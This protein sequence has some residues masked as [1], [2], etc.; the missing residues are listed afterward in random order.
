[1][2]PGEVFTLAPRQLGYVDLIKQVVAERGLP[3]TAARYAIAAAGAESSLTNWE[4]WGTSILVG[5]AEGRPLNA[6]ELAVA[7]RSK[8]LG[9]GPYRVNGLV[10]DNLDSMGLFAQR[11]MAGWGEPEQIMQPRYAIGKFL[12]R[13]VAVPDWQS[14]P[15]DQVIAKVQG[16][17]DPSVYANWLATA[18]ALTPNP[19]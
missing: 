5:K 18:Q 15:A 8:D 16:F 7:R 9:D 13:L 3:P 2:L 19:A 6:Q 14:L 17:Y 12:D 1:M 4:N 11:P 10:V